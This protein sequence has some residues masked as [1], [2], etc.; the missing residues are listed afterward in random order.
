[1]TRFL[2]SAVNRLPT[3]KKDVREP[4]IEDDNKHLWWREY[5]M[6]KQGVGS[7]RIEPPHEGFNRTLT[8]EAIP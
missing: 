3:Y 1:M 7:Y 8:P 6:D 5:M 4:L 2:Q